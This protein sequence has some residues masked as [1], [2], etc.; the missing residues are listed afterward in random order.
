MTTDDEWQY[1]NKSSLQVS[2]EEP[3]LRTS[4][5]G[6]R[7]PL[8]YASPAVSLM[9]SG[10]RCGARCE[11]GIEYCCEV[12]VRHLQGHAGSRNKKA[13]LLQSRARLQGLM[14][15][16]MRSTGLAYQKPRE[17][18]P[19]NSWLFPGSTGV[20]EP[21]QARTQEHLRTTLAQLYHF[22]HATG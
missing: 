1:S 5:P 22:E 20:A 16:R 2:R 17:R 4:D 18:Q 3:T 6:V 13:G 8:A 12:V 7:W 11:F 15:C 19:V 9:L 21:L 14:M 10:S